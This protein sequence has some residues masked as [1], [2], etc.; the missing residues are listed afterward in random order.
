MLHIT[1]IIRLSHRRQVVRQ[2][3]AVNVTRSHDLVA[4]FL[5]VVFLVGAAFFAGAAF[6]FA[7]PLV[8]VDLLTRPDLVFFSGSLAGA[9]NGL[10]S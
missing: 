5:G 9:C 10:V 3:T 8:V 6:V 2:S 7:A 1:Y 4:A